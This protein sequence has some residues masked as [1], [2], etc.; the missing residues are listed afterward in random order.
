MTKRVFRIT[1][2]FLLALTAIPLNMLAQATASGSIQGTVT[3]SADAVVSG[4]EVSVISLTTDAKR[5]AT[6]NSAGSYRFDLLP[7]GKYKVQISA[8]GFSTVVETVELLV[9]QTSNSNVTL[10]PG[11]TTQTVEVTSESSAG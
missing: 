8:A 10:K 3:D 11:A 2:L 5:T 1:L 4:A 9:G 7:V 6:T